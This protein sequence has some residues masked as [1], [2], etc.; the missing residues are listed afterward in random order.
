VVK[1]KC[2]IIL[3]FLAFSS[4][5]Y[6]QGWLTDENNFETNWNVTFQIGPTVLLTEL[7]KDFSGASNEMNNHSDVGFSFQLAKMVW[8]RV[9]LG[10]EFGVSNYKGSRENPSNVNYLMLSGFYNNKDGDFQPYP[11]YYNSE[12]SNFTLYSKYNFINFRSFSK[13]FIRLNLYAKM[14]LGVVFISSEMGYVNKANY[15]LT[16]LSNPLFAVGHAPNP[17][18]K[19]H[20]SFNPSFG[21]N[22]QLSDRFFISAETSFQLI[23]ADY[24]DGVYN[25]NNKLTLEI[26]GSLPKDYRVKV[27]DITGKIMLGITYF[28]NFDSH[29]QTRE[30]AFPWYYNR[31]RSYYSKFQTPSTKKA[32]KER[33]PFYNIK[34]G[35]LN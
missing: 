25:F 31:Y 5:A 17:V 30:K 28:F 12:I 33:L 1:D 9:D 18:K 7:K 21:M 8:E 20:F 2:L 23:N 15:E 16:G 4:V 27:Y 24:I 14:G 22:Y 26:D 35:D 32:R 34:F 11:I 3:A 13:G 19:T 10:F 6:P 29:R